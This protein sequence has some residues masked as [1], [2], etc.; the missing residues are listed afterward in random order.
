MTES[1]SILPPRHLR[2]V[3]TPAHR[4]E[5]EAWAWM[6]RTVRDRL[7]ELA[8]IDQ[9]YALLRFHARNSG[10]ITEPGMS[11]TRDPSHLIELRLLGL[12]ITGADRAEVTRNGLEVLNNVLDGEGAA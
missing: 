5:A 4:T 12:T 7:L 1:A 6:R 10:W 9:R 3:P 8:T 11:A 2:A